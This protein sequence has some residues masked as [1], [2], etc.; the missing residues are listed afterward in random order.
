MV[1]ISARSMNHDTV[2]EAELAEASGLA[3]S[4]KT[5]GILYTHND[6]GGKPIVYTLNYSG[7]MPAKI[8]LEGVTN[9]DW[10]DIAVGKDPA[11]GQSCVY[12]G[13][14][15]DNNAKHP[16]VYVYRFAEPALEDTLL[17]VTRTDR[18]EIAYDDGPRDA[19]ALMVDPRNGDIFIISKREE[20]VGVYRVAY[21]Q[22]LTSLNTA[23]KIAT[24]PYNWVTA[25]NFSPNGQQILVKTYT[26]IFRYKRSTKMSLADALARKYKTLPYK[27]EGQGEAVT[28]DHKGKGYFTL[29]ERVGDAPAELYYYK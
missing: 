2:E 6:S 3:A 15:G 17:R 16:S 9:R 22:S 4:I 25:A 5:P 19:E 11:S 21:P 8:V 29:S 1:L 18:I 14:I 26:N 27:L 28:Y 20:Q 7:L 13:D 12:V 23:K 24:L 10:E